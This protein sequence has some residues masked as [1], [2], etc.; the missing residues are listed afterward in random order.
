MSA[1]AITKYIR[2]FCSESPPEDYIS[3]VGREANHLLFRHSMLT[4]GLFQKPHGRFL[5]PLCR[6]KE[7]DRIAILFH[8]AVKPFE[9]SLDLDGQL[10]PEPAT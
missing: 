5:I 3:L 6:Q 7:V 1:G 9:F 10:I 2:A 8:C 4:N